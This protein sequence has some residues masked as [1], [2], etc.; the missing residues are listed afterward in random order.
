MKLNLDLILDNFADCSTSRSLLLATCLGSYSE[1]TS[2]FGSELSYR[3]V[4]RFTE[5][6]YSLSAPFS[7]NVQLKSNGKRPNRLLLALSLCLQIWAKQAFEPQ[8][9]RTDRRAERVVGEIVGLQLG[10]GRTKEAFKFWSFNLRN[11]NPV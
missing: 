8:L 7:S 2:N 6:D 9:N 10:S 3:P 5:C 4:R 1:F 11:L